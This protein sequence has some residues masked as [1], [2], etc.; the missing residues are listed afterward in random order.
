MPCEITT[1]DTQVLASVSHIY[2]ETIISLFSDSEKQI[3]CSVKRAN[4]IE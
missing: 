4:A 1:R 2:E 3:Y